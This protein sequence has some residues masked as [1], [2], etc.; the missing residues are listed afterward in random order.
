MLINY[1]LQLRERIPLEAVRREI[2]QAS[3]APAVSDLLTADDTS[4]KDSLGTKEDP[5][6]SLAPAV[7]DSLTMKNIPAKDSTTKV[8]PFASAS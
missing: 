3:A 4:E 8:I 6:A 1:S 7:S 5:S 2:T